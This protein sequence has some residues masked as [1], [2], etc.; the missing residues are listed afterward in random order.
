MEAIQI[1]GVQH[2]FTTVEGV[3]ED[4]TDIVLNVK[5]LAFKTLSRALVIEATAT[6]SIDGPGYRDRRL[7][8]NI[9]D[10]VHARSTPSTLS[11][12]LG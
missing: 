4:V 12:T 11:A 10:R 9:P 5:G 8:C 1:D 2:E 7:I 3:Y 6:I